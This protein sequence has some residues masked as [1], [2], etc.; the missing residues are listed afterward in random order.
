MH[1]WS[2]TPFQ[3]LNDYAAHMRYQYTSY[4]VVQ[5]QFFL[6]GPYTPAKQMPSNFENPPPRRSR[7]VACPLLSSLWWGLLFVLYIN[8]QTSWGDRVSQWLLIWG[9]QPTFCWMP[10]RQMAVHSCQYA[11]LTWQSFISFIFLKKVHTERF[12]GCS[13]CMFLP[14]VFSAV[15]KWYTDLVITLFPGTGKSKG[16]Q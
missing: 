14:F 8:H 10:L 15:V 7:W 2:E 11:N 4:L 3:H 9:P 1:Q 6:M 13:L 16:K 12:D 5:R